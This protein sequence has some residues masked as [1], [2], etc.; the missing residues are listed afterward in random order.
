MKDE[1]AKILSSEGNSKLLTYSSRQEYISKSAEEI[2]KLVFDFIHWM[3]QSVSY[4]PKTKSYLYWEDHYTAETLFAYWYKQEHH[5]GVRM[6]P[7]TSSQI[8]SVGY[9]S[10]TLYIE[11]LKGAVYSYDKVPEDVYN[12]LLLAKSVGKYFASDI[13]GK[14]D[15]GKTDK[16]VTNGELK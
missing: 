10:N 3:E 13:K 9:A 11:F 7:V 15:Y 16:I 14:F 2:E 4:N 8:K 5:G 6:L 12:V 1:I